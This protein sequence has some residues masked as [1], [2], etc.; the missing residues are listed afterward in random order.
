MELSSRR[1]V[2]EPVGPPAQPRRGLAACCR[3]TIEQTQS[4]GI[5][6]GGRERLIYFAERGWERNS[7]KLWPRLVPSGCRQA[8]GG[9]GDS[10]QQSAR[11]FYSGAW[12]AS[13]ADGPTLRPPVRP[14]ARAAAA[15]Q[16]ER[17]WPEEP[18]RKRGT[19]LTSSR[20]SAPAGAPGNV[21]GGAGRE[22]LRAGLR[23]G[24]RA[25]SSAGQADPTGARLGSAR[26][27]G[28]ASGEARGRVQP[29]RP[30][31][32]RQRGEPPGQGLRPGR[33]R[34]ART[35]APGRA[36]AETPQERRA[37]ARSG[38]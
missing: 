36:G 9:E 29:G 37:R 11:G 23:P 7:G 34:G 15:G 32:A 21:A 38:T 31:P 17:L 24:P 2:K 35:L 4:P 16:K 27:A 6:R 25:S 26:G 22:A 33:P 5:C 28:A 3:T 12:P 1:P 18:E 30:L 14:R 13:R 8:G 10:S 19:Q 20:L